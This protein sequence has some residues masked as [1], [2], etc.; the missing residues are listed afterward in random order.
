VSSI[1]QRAHEIIATSGHKLLPLSKVCRPRE[2]RTYERSIAGQGGFG[3]AVLDLVL[4]RSGKIR[5]IEMNGSNAGATSFANANGDRPRVDHFVETF[6]DNLLN[7]LPSAMVIGYAPGTGLLHEIVD[8]AAAIAIAFAAPLCTSDEALRTEETV[9]VVD[10]IPKLAA[11]MHQESNRLT[12]RDRPVIAMSNANLLPELARLGRIRPDYT[13]VSGFD[14]HAPAHEGLLTWLTHDRAA[15]QEVCDG[16]GIIP[17]ECVLAH[18]I[19]DAVEIASYFARR[20]KHAFGKI[21]GGSGSSGVA[22]FPARIDPTAARNVV[23][24]MIR[25]ACS[26]YG[27]DAELTLWPIR[28]FEATFSTGYKMNGHEHLWDMRFMCLIRP[29]CVQ[30][31]PCDMRLCPAPFDENSLSREAVIANTTGREPTVDFMRCP[32][33]VHSNLNE[34][35]MHHAGVSDQI[36]ELMCAAAANW[37]ERALAASYSR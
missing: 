22:F 27:K 3:I 23:E 20:Q 28:F 21:N 34:L 10:S 36:F 31:M 4:D 25:H 26:I 14:I 1:R 19:E 16:T 9:V 24:N 7:G 29:E 37:C 18:R 11:Q 33:A 35:E 12:I 6:S 5:L 13:T 8:R 15:Q 17:Q 30:V 32:L 2:Y